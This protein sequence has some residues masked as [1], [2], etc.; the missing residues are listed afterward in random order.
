MLA[1]LL[2]AASL[3]V[4]ETGVVL[5]MAVVLLTKTSELSTRSRVL[6]MCSAVPMVLWRVYVAAVL[7]PD[8][9]WQGLIYSPHV[10]TLPF[11]G[12]AGLWADLASGRHHPEDPN[13]IRGAFWFSLVLVGIAIAAWRVARAS[14][15]VVGA[16]LAVYAVMAL[17]F[18]HLT[19]WS[20]VANGQ[21]ASYEVFVL[22]AVATVS[23]RHYTPAVK[24]TLVTCW[25]GVV[26]YLFLGAHD[27]LLTRGALFPWT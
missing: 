18:T 19:V 6:L 14:G 7:W 2:F 25:T 27:V 11:A 3:L 12:L 15:R 9:G 22:L 16:A 13:L 5:V 10:M 17:S 8:W 24:A 4:R 1:T 20:H 26:L 21:R 23:F